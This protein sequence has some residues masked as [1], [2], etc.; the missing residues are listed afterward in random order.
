MAPLETLGTFSFDSTALECGEVFIATF[1]VGVQALN[2]SFVSKQF[3]LLKGASGKL[4]VYFPLHCSC[5]HQDSTLG[6]FYFY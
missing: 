1:S 3:I 6:H 5:H 2:L 4:D